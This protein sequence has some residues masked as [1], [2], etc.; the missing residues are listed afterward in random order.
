MFKKGYEKFCGE[1]GRRRF[2]P[3]RLDYDE[4]NQS[5]YNKEGKKNMSYNK[6]NFQEIDEDRKNHGLDLSWNVWVN[7]YARR[8]LLTIC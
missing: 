2:Y 3:T 4:E 1:A 6:Y 8:I 7:S 5:F